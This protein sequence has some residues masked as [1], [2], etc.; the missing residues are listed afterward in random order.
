MEKSLSD[1]LIGPAQD[2]Q[3]R[4]NEQS[5]GALSVLRKDGRAVQEDLN[6][7]SIMAQFAR[8]C[9]AIRAQLGATDHGSNQTIAEM[10][11]ARNR[12]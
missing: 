3:I 7:N 4:T 9:G 6:S 12:R 10:V 5:F 11:Q 1:W 2:L 8:P